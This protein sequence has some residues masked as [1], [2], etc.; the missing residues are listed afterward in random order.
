MYGTL[1]GEHGVGIEKRRFM[2]LEFNQVQLEI[3]QWIKQPFDP[4]GILNLGK[5]LP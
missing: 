2:T 1:S 5:L 3:M 4:E